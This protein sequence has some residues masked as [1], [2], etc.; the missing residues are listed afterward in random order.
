MLWIGTWNFSDDKGVFEN[1]PL[2]IKSQIFP[3]RTDI[4]TEQIVSWLD[5]LVTARY[6]VPFDFNGQGYFINRTF[7]THQRIDKPQP[8]KIPDKILGTLL[9][10][11]A[12]TPRTLPPDS[13]G[14]ERKG[15][16]GNGLRPPPGFEID[17]DQL[18]ISKAIEYLHLT[19]QVSAT[20]EMIHSLWTV[21]KEKNFTG[22]KFYADVGEIYGHFFNSLKFENFEINKRNTGNPI[23]HGTSEAR[24]KAARDW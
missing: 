3:R 1:D 15:R 6:I 20:S 24:I 17:I 8:S 14:K 13:K 18:R 12:N 21:F 4:R 5:Q 10:H 19:K 7:D 9:E 11:S 2:L 16:E 23:K 22:E